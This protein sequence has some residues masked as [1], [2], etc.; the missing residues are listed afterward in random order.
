MK[1]FIIFLLL[2]YLAFSQT[3]T[4]S[5]KSAPMIQSLT[6]PAQTPPTSSGKDVSNDH[7][8]RYVRNNMGG[9]QDL[10]DE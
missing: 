1:S 3:Q 2:G 10:T 6:A 8:N 4:Q 7:W 5:T 9:R